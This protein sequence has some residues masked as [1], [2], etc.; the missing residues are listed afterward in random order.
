MD[1][2]ATIDATAQAA[3]VPR[4]SGI[5]GVGAER[6]L[7]GSF[8]NERSCGVEPALHELLA[9]VHW[10]VAPERSHMPSRGAVHGDDV[11]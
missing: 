7:A 3:R 6:A 4:W 10:Q 8:A 5:I 1:T 11:F 2:R 9:E